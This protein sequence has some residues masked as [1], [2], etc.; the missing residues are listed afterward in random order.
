MVRGLCGVTWKFPRGTACPFLKVLILEFFS[1]FPFLVS[2]TTE[3]SLCTNQEEYCASEGSC[4]GRVTHK[5]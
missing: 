5:T 2:T 3:Y 4:E 1:L